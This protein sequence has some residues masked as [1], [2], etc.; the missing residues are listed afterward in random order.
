ME[1]SIISSFTC[2]WVRIIIY[3]FKLHGQ[4][5]GQEG[6]LNS[7]L[8]TQALRR[9]S[10]LFSS[11]HLFWLALPS[12]LP[13]SFTHSARLS[14]QVCVC[15]SVCLSVSVCLSLSLIFP[16]LPPSPRHCVL[17][18]TYILHVSQISVSSPLFILHDDTT[19]TTAKGG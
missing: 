9:V 13:L 15:A 17:I 4:R 18:L 5:E 3:L 1:C 16:R 8:C 14:I 12:P 10:I 11:S 6:T 19:I 7:I 2:F